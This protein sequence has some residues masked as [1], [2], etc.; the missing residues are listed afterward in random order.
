MN[1]RIK[2][3][4]PGMDPYLEEHWGDVHTR[5]MVYASNQLNAQLPGD[6]Q[7][8]VEEALSVEADE[9]ERTV[10]P[11][12]QVVEDRD[13]MRQTGSAPAARAVAELMEVELPDET[14]KQRHIEIVDAASNRLVTA[15]E[16]LSR[17]NKIGEA[18]RAKYE[19]KQQEYLHAGAN[20]V[21]ID[22]LRA[23]SFVLAIPE[24]YWPHDQATYKICV[25][26]A[27]RRRIAL[28]L[29]ISLREPLPNIRIPLRPKDKEVVLQLQPIIDDCYCDGR[30]ANI[31]YSKPP[32]PP[33][34]GE[35]RIWAEQVIR[36]RGT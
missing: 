10:Y 4:F 6:L 21:E 34:Q 12:V 26:R 16:L 22:L 9:W 3:P 14:P 2:S 32:N 1:L 20:L 11:D 5:F 31:D 8:R 7:A 27:R 13:A 28:T 24:A 25:R 18:G 23:G 29:G 30:Y 35:D 15:I 33:L 19:R 17:A 36:E